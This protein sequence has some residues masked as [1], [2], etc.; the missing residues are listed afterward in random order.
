MPKVHREDESEFAATAT[1]LRVPAGL[2][3][4]AFVVGLVTGAFAGPL[5]A[6]PASVVTYVLTLIVC[7]PF[8]MP[9]AWHHRHPA[10]RVWMAAAAAIATVRAVIMA[11]YLLP[12][13]PW[14]AWIVKTVVDLIV[15][16]V[17]WLAV[18]AVSP[19]ASYRTSGRATQGR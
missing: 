16:A 1:L 10:L 4:G 17:L 15:A 11:G 2:A 5:S 7:A 19:W 6:V 3:A 12:Y 9:S 18:L 14:G 8:L 13:Q